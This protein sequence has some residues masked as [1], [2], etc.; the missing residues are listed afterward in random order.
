MEKDKYEF[1]VKLL[2]NTKIS[3]SQRA[4]VVRLIGKEFREDFSGVDEIRARLKDIEEKVG[5]NEKSE[6]EFEKKNSPEIIPRPRDVAEFMSL[7]NQ[8][9]GLKY[10][11][12][13][14]DEDKNFNLREFLEKSKKVFTKK[15]R[16]LKIPKSLWRIVNE[17]AFKGDQTT[18]TSIS[19]NYERKEIKSSWASNEWQEWSVSNKSHPI[20][21]EKFK[22]VIDDFRRITRIDRN[23]EKLVDRCIDNIFKEEKKD[24][25]IIKKDLAKAD[26]YTHVEFFKD[27]LEAIFEEIKRTAVNKE[28][29]KLSITYERTQ[30]GKGDNFY[31]VRQI[32]IFHK[33][34]FPIKTKN[35]LL[36]EWLSKEK[37]NMGKIAK[38]LNGYC[39]WSVETAIENEP[40][41]VNILREK[42]TPASTSIEEADGF[43]HI[44]TFYYK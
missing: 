41:R 42:N 22:E 19:E 28:T 16:E 1:M 6:S 40:I 2:E 8:R 38:K 36:K 34:S 39:Y 12:H 33:N 37:G 25:E 5:V 7:F 26:F 20:K 9:D 24:L 4:K 11:T 18:W 21:N 14:Y 44:L 27:T 32:I 31:N 3:M 15:T 35:L 30:E 17:F 29:K 13:D 43:K 23:L 10:L